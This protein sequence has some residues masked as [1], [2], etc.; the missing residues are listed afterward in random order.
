[1]ARGG[2]TGWLLDPVERDVLLA[3]IPPAYPDVIADHVTLAVHGDARR[4][5]PTPVEAEI[6]GVVDD[7]D[8]LQALVVE[9]DG[10]TARPDGGIYHITWSLDRA[11]GRKPVHSNDALARLGWTPLPRR[12]IAVT[13]VRRLG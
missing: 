4:L 13:P 3:D 11:R 10:S 6:V 12:R 9:L 5:A 8:G 1:M 7:G 2:F